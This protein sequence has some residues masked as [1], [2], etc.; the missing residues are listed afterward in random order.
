MPITDKER[1][2]K[3]LETLLRIRNVLTI[4]QDKWGE[5]ELDDD[6]DKVKKTIDF[7][8]DQNADQIKLDL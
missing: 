8:L 5:P 7:V 3:L 4:V 6:L 2:E 1:I